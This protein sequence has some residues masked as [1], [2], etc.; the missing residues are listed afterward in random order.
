MVEV[1]KTNV[2]SSIIANEIIAELN[3]VLPNSAISF[4][5]EDC[6]RVLRIE[7]K[8]IPLLRVIQALKQRGF[9]CEELE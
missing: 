7:S 4:D 2:H 5:L 6:D 9:S 1:F 8:S 3:T